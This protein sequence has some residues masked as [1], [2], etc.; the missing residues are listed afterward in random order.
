M[1]TMASETKA[2]VRPLLR[3]SKFV[4]LIRLRNE[5]FLSRL[6]SMPQRKSTRVTRMAENIE[7]TMPMVRVTAKPLMVPLP[8]QNRMMAVM[9]EVKFESKIAVKAFS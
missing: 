7:A 5:S 3:K 2:Q 6:R 4:A 1:S 9:S 8:I